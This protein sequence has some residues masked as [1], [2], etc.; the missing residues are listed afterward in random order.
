MVRG[1]QGGWRGKLPVI[2]FEIAAVLKDFERALKAFQNE[3]DKAFRELGKDADPQRRAEVGS[4]FQ[5]KADALHARSYDELVRINAKHKEIPHNSLAYSYLDGP[6]GKLEDGTLPFIR[7]LHWNRHSESLSATERRDAGGDL[8]AWDDLHRT[9]ADYRT[10]AHRKGRIKPFKHDPVH[11][12]L[13]ELLLCF[14]N[15]TDPLT[16]DERAAC[17]D[18]CCACG[19]SHAAD[20]LKRQYARLKRDLK[21]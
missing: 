15:E 6:D 1:W 20:A 3:A 17:F 8:T 4:L 21:S 13:L 12:E 2:F 14:E 18:E 11:R 5:Q 10:L 19:R 9:G 7:W 16:A